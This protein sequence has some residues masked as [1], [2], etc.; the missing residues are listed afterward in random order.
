MVRKL[1][2]A[3]ILLAAVV[4]NSGC[5]FQISPT[6]ESNN[7]FSGVIIGRVEMASAEKASEPPVPVV[8]QLDCTSIS[9]LSNADG[10]FVI[11]NIPAGT[12]GLTAVLNTEI[13]ARAA[14]VEVHEGQNT[15]LDTMQLSPVGSVTGRVILNGIGF[16]GGTTVALYGTEM[17]V[18]TTADGTF[19]IPGVPA[20]T[21]SVAA[22]RSGYASTALNGVV[23][24]SGTQCEVAEIELVQI[25]SLIDICSLPDGWE[26]AYDMAV[27]PNGKYLA[28]VLDSVN[29]E[30]DI[31]ICTLEDRTWSR[32]TSTSQADEYSPSWSPSGLR[33]VWQREEDLYLYD[34]ASGVASKLLNDSHSP[35]WC[36]ASNRIYFEQYGSLY[37]LPSSGGSPR[38]LLEGAF[39]PS[40]SVSGLIA[41][42]RSDGTWVMQYD[43][44]NPVRVALYGTA[45]FWSASKQEVLYHQG[46]NISMVDIVTGTAR[47][48]VSGAGAAAYGNLYRRLYF[49]ERTSASI[50]ALQQ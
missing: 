39:S 19:T 28:S 43:G 8:V 32:V 14:I 27:S 35:S 12:Y 37:V 36:R 6:D 46:T 47:V 31:W 50:K 3:A 1:M 23:V 11:E 49:F 25:G 33:M 20:G 18:E 22:G 15:Y 24:S 40:C 34:C 5:T 41:C 38:W 48:L 9:A 10:S 44:N 13:K 45:P 16:P 26:Y 2:V 42:E 7:S 21:F 4:C 29:G 30:K 17:I